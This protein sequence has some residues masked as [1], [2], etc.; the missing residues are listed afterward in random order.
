VTAV[1]STAVAASV[2]ATMAA[3]ETVVVGQR[4]GMVI[5]VATEVGAVLVMPMQVVLK[6]VLQVRVLPVTVV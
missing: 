3:V 2:A 1:V 4:R 6:E 5:E